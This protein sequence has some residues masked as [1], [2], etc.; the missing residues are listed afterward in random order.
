[1]T[2]ALLLG[3][4]ATNVA[5][6]TA[7]TKFSTRL[8]IE[9]VEIPMDR[10]TGQLSIQVS[11]G[12]EGPLAFDLDTYVVTTACVD[13]EFAKR[14][15]FE[16]VGTVMNGD[17]SGAVHERDV[18]LIPELRFGHATFSN[19]EA[20]VDDYSW[21]PTPSGESI[22]GLLGYHLFKELLLELD[23]PNERILLRKGQ[24]PRGGKHVITYSALKRRPDIPVLI[25]S[26]RIVFGIDTGAEAQISMTQALSE[27]LGLADES[28]LVGT[29][30]TVYSSS[31][32]W[33][34]TFTSPFT[35]AGHELNQVNGSF[36]ELFKT[37][38]IGNHL[39]ENFS[40]T[41]D[42]QTGRIQFVAEQLS[43]APK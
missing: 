22:K 37:P 36:C 28:V 1:L 40:V 13:F 8:A 17:G 3:L 31:K 20:L 16:K 6:N 23:Y 18:V 35:I 32:V 10:S 24:L 26:K 25:G 19:V 39:L 14:M 38:L 15:G 30:R 12:S 29:A 33:T 5:P 34:G 4:S 2:A 7:N 21:V 27:E 9:V 11:I 41:F 42:Q 43:I